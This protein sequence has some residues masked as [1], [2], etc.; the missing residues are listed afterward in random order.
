VDNILCVRLDARV[1]RVHSQAGRQNWMWHYVACIIS[2]A[3]Y[4]RL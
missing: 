3:W 4:L 2:S 1:I